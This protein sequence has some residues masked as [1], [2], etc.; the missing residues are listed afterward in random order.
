MT[1][2]S[3]RLLI[4]GSGWIASN[5]YRHAGALGWT[6]KVCY[7]FHRTP[8]VRED[9][10]LHLPDTHGALADLFEDYRPQFV[11]IA[12][13]TSFVPQI[14]SDVMSA[15][16][17]HVGQTV[18]ILGA[19]SGGG[20]KPAKILSIG[21]ASEYGVATDIPIREDA[22]I[23][24]SDAYGIIKAAQC[25]VAMTYARHFGLNVIH[26]RQFNASGV[27]QRKTFVLPSIASQVAAVKK[28]G[29]RGSVTVG[30]VE[31]VRDFLDIRDVLTAYEAVLLHGE[32]GQCYNVCSGRGHS[33][34]DAI[35]TASRIAAVD[36]E[37]HVDPSLVRKGEKRKP[38]VIGDAT[39]LRS[40]GWAPRYD[41]G[42]ILSSLL[43]YYSNQPSI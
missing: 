1:D 38:A 34:R 28:A 9:H 43:D 14:E 15:I 17:S 19:L 41:L 7:R 30:D 23:A 42:A 13:G 29:R 2:V 31:V 25:S 24:P 39:R 22:A 37:L 18:R 33:V 12:G 3:P 20:W 40:L 27:G 10:L 32:A 4:F 5:L 8:E 35:E 21:S 16:N 11:V 26:I 6:C 36:V